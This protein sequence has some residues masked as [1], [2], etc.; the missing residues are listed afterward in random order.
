[1]RAA[2]LLSLMLASPASSQ[3]NL[4]PADRTAAFKAAG[5]SQKGGQ[6]RSDCDDPGGAS[7][8]P[9]SVETTGDFNGDRLPDAVITESSSA[10][11]GATGA[12]YAVVSKQPTGAWKLM[13]RG[14][15]MITMLPTRGVG[16]WPDIEIGGPGFC[17]PVH[18]WNGRAYAVARFQYEGKP[19]R[20]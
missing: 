8:V 20:R 16:G 1:M 12:S 10:C 7:Y 2:V 11:F 14:V 18:R 5:F 19:C 15:G 6:W 3:D 17:F 13:T 9:G 4:A